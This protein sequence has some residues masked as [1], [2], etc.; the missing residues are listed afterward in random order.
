MSPL[1]DGMEH[2]LLKIRIKAMDMKTGQEPIN[3]LGA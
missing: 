2:S 1:L 3:K